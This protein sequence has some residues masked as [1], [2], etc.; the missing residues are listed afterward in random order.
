[1]FGCRGF[2]VGCSPFPSIEV[3]ER[4]D[5]CALSEHGSTPFPVLPRSQLIEVARPIIL[6]KSRKR[7]IGENAT[8]GLTSRAV[9][10]LV[11]GVANSLNRGRADRAGLTESSVHGHA[12]TERRDFLRKPIAGLGPKPLSPLR[13]ETSRVAAYSRSAS[14]FDSA[15]G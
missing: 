12:G 15:F 11:V 8:L 13:R 14:D 4:D 6:Q 5:Q 3:A 1:M 9:V 7:A 10:G 2:D